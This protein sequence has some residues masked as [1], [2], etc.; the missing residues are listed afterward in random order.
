MC[1]NSRA[2]RWALL[3][4]ACIACSSDTSSSDDDSSTTPSGPASLTLVPVVP[5]GRPSGQA[6][7]VRVSAH[8]AQGAP[9]V[10]ATVTMSANDGNVQF[11]PSQGV[12]TSNG[13][14]LVSATSRVANSIL[15]AATIGD[16]TRIT[17]VAFAKPCTA[18]TLARQQMIVLASQGQQ[19]L[20]MGDINGDGTI[21]LLAQSDLG[22]ATGLLN[23]GDGGFWTRGPFDGGSTLQILAPTMADLTGDGAIDA[24]AATGASPKALALFR[25]IGNGTFN[26][27][28]A[29]PTRITSRPLL[30]DI[31]GDGHTD[32][33]G[34]SAVDNTFVM[35]KGSGT[36]QF[37]TNLYPLLQGSQPGDVALGDFN[38]DGRIDVVAANANGPLAIFYSKA[39]NGFAA[40]TSVTLGPGA[41]ALAAGDVDNDGDI[42]IVTVASTTTYIYVALNAGNNTFQ[43]LVST[44]VMQ[45]VGRFALADVDSDGNL[46]F[47]AGIPAASAMIVSSG[48]GDGTFETA[49]TLD[50]GLLHPRDWAVTDINND[51][52]ADMAVAAQNGTMVWV[53]VCD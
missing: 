49:V 28:T 16:Q 3:L 39:P 31:D 1:P 36:G 2:S 14:L 29:V 32:I 13:T 24:I 25:N 6:V 41:A 40:A 53:N 17:Q 18:L 8:D 11:S 4:T 34:A 35:L 12:T 30:V 27:A 45:G 26:P 46:D 50:V 48:R 21:D 7:R 38:G 37:A 51:G 10:G 44:S 15:L 22:H 9:L 43:N 20:A 33:V 19:S 23:E 47:I 5:T 42:D 52:R